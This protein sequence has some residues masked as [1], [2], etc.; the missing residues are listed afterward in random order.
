VAGALFAAALGLLIA[1]H[2]Q[3]RAQFDQ[4]Q[5]S[6][7]VT[8]EVTGIVAVELAVLRRDVHLLTMQVGNDSTALSQDASQ[9]EGAE[10]ALTDAQTHS[11]QQTS[12][13]SSL[14]TCL[15]GVEKTLNALSVGQQP[16]AIAALS[17][18]GPSCSAAAA[19]SG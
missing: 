6:L 13:I 18:V 1:D 8:R 11:S 5:T 16:Q 14:R 10:S 12:L 2:V 9:L 19:S 4:A 15:G 7:A 17:A 3:Q